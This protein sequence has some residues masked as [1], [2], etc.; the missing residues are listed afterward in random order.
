MVSIVLVIVWEFQVNSKFHTLLTA[1]NDKI[2]MRNTLYGS[3][4]RRDL[5]PQP[6]DRQF[7]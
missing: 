7:A 4:T 5:N 6:Y 2:H 3:K 1:I